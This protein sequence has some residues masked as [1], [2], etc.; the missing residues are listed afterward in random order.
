MAM[1]KGAYL[2][3]PDT[4]DFPILSHHPADLDHDNMPPLYT[5]LFRSRSKGD[6]LSTLLQMPVPTC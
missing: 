4:R 6:D 2:R 5:V 1:I 3:C